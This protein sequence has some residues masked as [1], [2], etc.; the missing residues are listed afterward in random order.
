[1]R[2]V[3]DEPSRVVGVKELIKACVADF[4]QYLTVEKSK[5]EE[6][7]VWHGPNPSARRTFTA[8]R[9]DGPA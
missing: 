4:Q 8:G 1:M 5:V 6:I 9:H 2:V 3:R 7:R